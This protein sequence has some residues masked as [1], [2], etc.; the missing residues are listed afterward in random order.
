MM[1]FNPALGK[2]VFELID[3]IY[4]NISLFAGKQ[5]LIPYSLCVDS[6]ACVPPMQGWPRLKNAGQYLSK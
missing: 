3:F 1:P 4:L 2:S 5:D 6:L